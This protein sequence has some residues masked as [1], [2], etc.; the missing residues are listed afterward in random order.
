MTDNPDTT[1]MRGQPQPGQRTVGQRRRPCQVIA[2]RG[3]GAE[4]AENTWAAVA[5]TAELGLDW[6]ET[7]LRATLDGVVVLAHDASLARTV[8]DDRTIGQMT[9]AEFSQ[10]DAGDGK[11]P[12]R[13]E[14][15]LVRYPS[16]CLNVDLK[17]AT[18]IEPA[19]RIVEECG[20]QERVRFASFSGRRL[21]LLRRLLPQ[22]RTSLGMGDVA[23]LV[24]LS[25]AGLGSSSRLLV[26]RL[27]RRADG[28]SGRRPDAVQVPERQRGVRVLS[29][30]FIAAAHAGGLEV[31]VWTV[32]RP[33]EMQRLAAMGVDA[34]ITDVPRV[35]QQILADS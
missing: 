9:W 13:L 26:Q 8:G 12:A 31:H 15:V 23:G 17:D 2:H 24:A 29:P 11:P 28:V 21:A 16:L 20:A 7:D 32:N 27:A 35:A 19:A 14:E 33:V 34:V 10:I 25:A 5:H 1:A 4:A 22:A 3:G 18:V 6:M 30:R